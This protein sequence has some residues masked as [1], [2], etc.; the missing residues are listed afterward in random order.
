MKKKTADLPDLHKRIIKMIM[1]SHQWEIEYLGSL[2]EGERNAVG[3]Y[4]QWSPKDRISHNTYWRRRAVEKLGYLFRGQTPPEYPPSEDC[5]RQNFEENREKAVP[6]LLKMADEVMTAL[7]LALS[8]FSEEDLRSTAY[9]PSLSGRSLLD[10]I[11]DQCYSHPVYHLSEGYLRLDNVR[12][13][14]Q[15]Q[16]QRMKDLDA[17]DGSPKAHAAYCYDRAC[18]YALT[19]E[20][21]KALEFL[22]ISLAGRPDLKTW[23]VQDPEVASLRDDSRFQKLVTDAAVNLTA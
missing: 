1:K 19:G 7:P 2:S 21:E 23:A 6:T 11:L 14:N 15:L 8:R 18:F 22:E 5:N 13:V 10:F 16:D 4:E 17:I 12:M 20:K 9:H 3:T